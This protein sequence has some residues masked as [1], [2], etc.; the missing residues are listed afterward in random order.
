LFDAQVPISPLLWKVKRSTVDDDNNKSTPEVLSG[1]RFSYADKDAVNGPV[2][3]I[4]VQLSDKKGTLSLQFQAKN[5]DMPVPP[6]NA[7]GVVG[8]M[9]GS[10]CF[11]EKTANCE[12][13]G[14]KLSCME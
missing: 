9:I 12:L 14:T 10:R 1:E 4:K 5:F 6:D 11:T 8:I 7:D 2:S 13:S 3:K